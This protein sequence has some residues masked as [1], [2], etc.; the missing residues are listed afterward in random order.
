[1]QKIVSRILKGKGIWLNF[2]RRKYINLLLVLQWICLPNKS[3]KNVLVVWKEVINYFP[4][5]S[6]WLV[7]KVGIGEN[8][9]L[10]FDPC[11]GCEGLHIL[12]YRML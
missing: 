10:G 1:M 7:W 8:F 6:D 11:V 12:S 5:I 9:L 2:I 4:F 3:Y